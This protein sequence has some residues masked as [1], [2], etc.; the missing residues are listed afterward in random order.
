M[1]TPWRASFSQE[2]RDGCLNVAWY[3]PENDGGW[4]DMQQ[5]G[6]FR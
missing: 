1:R 2:A 3:S 5:N 4:P 6:V